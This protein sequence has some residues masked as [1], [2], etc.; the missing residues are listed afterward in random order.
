MTRKHFTVVITDHEGKT[1]VTHKCVPVTFASGIR[2]LLPSRSDHRTIQM[3]NF[4]MFVNDDTGETY[5]YKNRWG[6]EGRVGY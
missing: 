2:E 3:A 1:T 4:V 5:I 6:C